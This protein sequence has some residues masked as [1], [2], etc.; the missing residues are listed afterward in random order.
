MLNSSILLPDLLAKAFGTTRCSILSMLIS[1]KMVQRTN[2]EMKP[3]N[4]LVSQ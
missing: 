1:N 3:R 4:K 2:I